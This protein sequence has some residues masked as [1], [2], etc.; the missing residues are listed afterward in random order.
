MKPLHEDQIHAPAFQKLC[1]FIW[2][3][4][5]NDGY[6]QSVIAEHNPILRVCNASIPPS[7]RGIIFVGMAQLIEHVFEGLPRHGEYIIIHRTNDRSFTP[8][9]YRMKPPSVKYVYTVDCAVNEKDVSAIPIGF[10]TIN[11]ED[12]LIKQIVQ[13]NTLPVPTK[14]FCRYNVNPA[15]VERI[16]SLPILKKKSFTKVVED[17]IP[18]DEFYRNIKA[19]KYTMS[20]RGCGPDAC[21]T[22]DAIALGSTPIVSECVELR[23]FQD[24]PV[25]YCPKDMNDITVEWLDSHDLTIKSM[26]RMRMSYWKNHLI[27]KVR[28]V[29][30]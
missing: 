1:D 17:Q 16:E 6:I 20:L 28:E 12:E 8:A 30:I 13:E 27:N 15:T 26:E 7:G 25:I 18:E 21:R 14:L 5:P 19:H 9:H 2:S 3:P 22:W 11:G 10:A 23:H 24:M 4:N 29:L